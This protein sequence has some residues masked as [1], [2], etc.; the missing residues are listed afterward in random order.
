MAPHTSPPTTMG[1]ARPERMPSART[2]S[3]MSAAVGSSVSNRA[4][5]PVL[6]TA[7]TT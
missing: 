2:G 6:R 5:R 4:A 7:A 1:M 3:G